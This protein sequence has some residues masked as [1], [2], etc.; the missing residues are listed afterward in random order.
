MLSKMITDRQKAAADL[1]GTVET[2]AAQASDVFLQLIEPDLE[3]GAL[4]PDMVHLQT[5]LS[6]R[7]DRLRKK[8]IEL[9]EVHNAERKE[10]RNLREQR[11]TAALELK[12]LLLRLRGVVDNSCGAGSCARFLGVEG[13]MP[14]DPV[15][16][17]RVANR[18]VDGLSEGFIEEADTLLAGIELNTTAWVD[19]LRDPMERLEDALVRLS[20]ENPETVNHLVTKNSVIAEYDRTYRATASIVESLFRYVGRADLA[21]RIRP[22]QRSPAGDS[23][24]ADTGEEVDEPPSKDG[25]EIFPEQAD[26]A[27][28]PV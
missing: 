13:P 25:V 26:D 4:P 17:L 10:D 12:D 22:K 16:I 21:E 6:R 24:A 5:L 1:S 19:Q 14:R 2:F 28:A 15:S 27:V 7:L 3:E 23:A 9:D 11:D 18:L 20:R 8:L